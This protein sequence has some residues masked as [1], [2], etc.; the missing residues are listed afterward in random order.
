MVIYIQEKRC[1]SSN[2]H[3]SIHTVFTFHQSH[4]MNNTSEL[5]LQNINSIIN[6]ISTSI[7]CQVPKV[8]NK[9]STNFSHHSKHNQDYIKVSQEMNIRKIII[10]ISS[11]ILSTKKVLHSYKRPFKD[12]N[13]MQQTV[14]RIHK[15]SAQKDVQE[16]VFRRSTSDEPL[17]FF[18][19]ND[20]LI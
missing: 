19:L 17:F 5:I 6:I 20:L 2:F 14:I 11:R 18:H 1:Q 10:E 7:T 13:G 3:N 4:S 15:Y 8:H 16:Q 9:H 12:C